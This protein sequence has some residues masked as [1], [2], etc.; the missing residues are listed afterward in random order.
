MGKDF[1]IYAEYEKWMMSRTVNDKFPS[2]WL[3]YEAGAKMMEE[4]LSKKK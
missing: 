2:M 1:N 3:A 4:K